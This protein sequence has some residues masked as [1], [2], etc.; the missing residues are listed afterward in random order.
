MRWIVALIASVVSLSAARAQIGPSWEQ[1]AVKR[2]SETAALG[3]TADQA[4]ATAAQK[5]IDTYNAYTRTTTTYNLLKYRIRM[6]RPLEADTIETYIAQA[7][8]FRY[9]GDNRNQQGE[10]KDALGDAHWSL[11][12]S[13]FTSE[14]YE[15]A[16]FWFDKCYTEYP[17]ATDKFNG[18]AYYY[19]LAMDQCAGA[20]AMM[21]KYIL[22]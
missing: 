15:E 13:A 20:D 22:P 18:A 12:S 8:G 1:A 10:Q 16:C 5:K 6:E 19:W 2:M 4:K 7:A 14:N 17:A 11:G 3:Q 9:E 21:A